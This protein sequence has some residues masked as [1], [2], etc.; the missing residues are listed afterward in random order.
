LPHSTINTFVIPPKS[1]KAF[2]VK[3]DQTF[4]IIDVKGG[5]PG[6][7]VAFN[8]HDHHESLGQARTR[9]EN[10]SCSVTAGHSIW[11]RTIPP[12]V[13]L[14]ITKNTK[15]R[16]DLLYTPCCRYALQKRFNLDDN[17]CFE[18]LLAA[19]EPYGLQANDI[20]DPL[21]LFFNV[22]LT[23]DGKL[24]IGDHSS[25][26]GDTF[27]AIAVMDCLMAVSTCPVPIPDRTH[28]EFIIEILRPPPR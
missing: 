18:N 9:V 6:D 2:K 10:Q 3:K 21:N 24:N 5:Q 13:M 20:P 28:S 14:T 12:E 22:N 11:T 16:H 26:A 4:R 15:T 8:L 7:L 27:E 17:G 23:P 1:A 25:P 19:L